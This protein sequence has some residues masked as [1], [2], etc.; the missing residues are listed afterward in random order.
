M[1]HL[2]NVS[3]A[4][5][6]ALHTM[7]LLATGNKRRLTNQQIAGSLRASGHHL[8][9]VM[10]RLAK[11]GLVDSIR[12]PQGGFLLKVPAE[13]VT[14]LAIYEAVEGPLQESGCLLGDP[15]CD[16]T[17][18]VLGEVVQSIHQQLRDYLQKTTLAE[19]ADSLG[20]L[21]RLQGP[22]NAGQQH[23]T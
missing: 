8:A 4:A 21:Q 17:R 22:G 13:Q 20:G 16:R 12:G 18:C 14:L 11:V 10:Q 19:L 3:E 5:S 1:S 2:V 7:A 15:I 9:K 6:L 23:R